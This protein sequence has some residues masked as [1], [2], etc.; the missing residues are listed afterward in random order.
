MNIVK[1]K[2]YQPLHITEA[3]KS[4]I[5]SPARIMA[6][7]E[8]PDCLGFYAKESAKTIGFALLRNY[9]D[10]EYFLWNFIIDHSHQG[11]GK[12]KVFLQRLL[13]ILQQEYNA[14]MLTTTYIYGNNTAKKLYESFGFMQ[15]DVVQEGD[16]HEVNM[17]LA[18]L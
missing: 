13:N 15:T 9:A 7:L 16:I 11:Q 8:Q 18:L 17:A 10:R 5:S 14:K 3:Q 1:T 12:G 2:T 4:Q 6:A